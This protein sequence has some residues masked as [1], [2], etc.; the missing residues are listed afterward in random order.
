MCGEQHDVDAEE[1]CG[2]QDG[3]KVAAVE[4]VIY[5]EDEGVRVYG[6]A[7]RVAGGGVD[8]CEGGLLCCSVDG[9]QGL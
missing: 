8:C 5:E 7:G 2:A 1:I 9:G 3:A 6:C 4:D